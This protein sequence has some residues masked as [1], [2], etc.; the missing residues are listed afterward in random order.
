MAKPAKP[1]APKVYWA[2]IDGLNEWIVA[3]PNRPDALAAFDLRQDLFAQ[4]LAGEEK[5]PAKI[6]AAR[7][8]PG[9]P[10]R[11][12]QGSKAPF[13]PA[14]AAADWS[15]ALP[16]GSKARA[17]AK[18]KPDRKALAQAE[19]RL[20]QIEAAHRQALAEIAADRAR[21]DE[22]ETRETDRYEAE[23]AEAEKRRDE[24][25]EG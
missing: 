16:K 7:A 3:A 10:L 25:K 6:E 8:S 9:T 21:L 22:R 23:R 12:P 5:D 17:N 24:A 18:P 15:A 13:A 14:D 1:R 4:G 2:E 20:K 19:A 11:R